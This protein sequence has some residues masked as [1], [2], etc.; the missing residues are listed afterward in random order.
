M[1]NF[2]NKNVQ[3]A[4]CYDQK[5][6]T[7]VESIKFQ[8]EE[9]KKF[10]ALKY[11]QNLNMKYELELLGEPLAELK[12]ENEELRQ[13]LKEKTARETIISMYS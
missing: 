8:Q 2:L 5:L 12:N 7:L 11:K 4:V 13:K 9:F 3:K 10:V 6:E 1:S